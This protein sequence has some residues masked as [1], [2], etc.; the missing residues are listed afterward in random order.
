M[1]VRLYTSP[2]LT[3]SLGKSRGTQVGLSSRTEAWSSAEVKLGD[4]SA[5]A[6]DDGAV[7]SVLG[8]SQRAPFASG[9]SAIRNLENLHFDSV[10]ESRT[11]F[12]MILDGKLLLCSP[13]HGGHTGAQLLV[14]C[15][16]II[17]A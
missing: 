6:P 7:Y 8:R 13:P 1:C 16:E 4:A 14:V 15:C 17:A 9:L 2:I 12:P 3:A 10:C 11:R 5:R